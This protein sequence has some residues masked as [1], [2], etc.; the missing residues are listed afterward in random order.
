MIRRRESGSALLEAL[1]GTAIIAM[2]VATMYRAVI[3]TAARNQM[4][5]LKRTALLVAQSELAGVGTIVPLEPGVSAGTQA[6]LNWRVE[7]SPLGSSTNVGQLWQI[8]V[9]VRKPGGRDL[10]HI[11]TVK[12]AGA[13]S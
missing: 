1:V 6:G 7:I 10:I 8:A 2:T 9:S 13:T 4:A 11:D 5:D 12:L 3:E